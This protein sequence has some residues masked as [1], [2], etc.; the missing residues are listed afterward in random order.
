MTRQ[1]IIPTARIQTAIVL[2]RGQKVLI[3]SDL[4]KFYQV[5]T[6]QIVRAVKRNAERFPADFMFQLSGEEF[7]SLKCQTGIAK[8]RGGRRTPPY[9]FTEQGV[10]MLASVLRSSRATQINIQIVRAFVNLRRL[11]ADNHKLADRLAKL[12]A[13]CNKSF[14]LIFETL[15]DIMDAK[16]TD[17]TKGRIGFASESQT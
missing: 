17:T 6:G 11:L 8:G 2:L 4:A 14:L 3:D 10:A 9:A 5:Q 15:T 7:D 12:E 16:P 13:D 1:S